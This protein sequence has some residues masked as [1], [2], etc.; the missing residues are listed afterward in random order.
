MAASGDAEFEPGFL[1][2]PQAVETFD[3]LVARQAL[4]ALHCDIS[5]LSKACAASAFR[6]RAPSFISISS[7]SAVCALTAHATQ[8]PLWAMLKPGCTPLSTGAARRRLA[9]LLFQRFP[10]ASTEQAAQRHAQQ[11][12]ADDE[13]ALPLRATKRW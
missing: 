8:R 10:A 7:P 1:L 13:L 9:D 3:P 12:P 5:T 2:A 6:S 11:H 4:Q